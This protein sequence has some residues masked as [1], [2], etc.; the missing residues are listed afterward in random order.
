MAGPNRREFL[1]LAAAL[2]ASLAWGVGCARPA[3]LRWTL[4]ADRFP[5]GV[6]SGDPDE[7]SV[8]LWTRRPPVDGDTAHRVTVEV[9]EDAAFDHVVATAGADVS[10]AS[11]WTAR[12]L[13]AGLAPARVYWYRFVDDRGHGSR[14]GRTVTA[15]EP[16]DPRPV[17]FAFVSCQN[18]CQGAQTAYRRMIFDDEHRASAEQ[19]GFVLHLGDFFYELIW[20]PEDR[21]QGMYARRLRDIVRFSPGEKIAD[22]HVPVSLD[23]YRSLFRAYLLDPDLQDARA[24]WPFV[25]MWDNHEF[26]WKGWQSLV[27]YDTA[28]PAQTRKV[29]AAQAWFEFQPARIVGPAGRRVAEF[30]A[31]A[32]SGAPVADAPIE[33]FDEHGLGQEPNNLAA[34][35]ALRLYRSLRFGAHLDLIL[36]DNR[37]FQMEPVMNRPEAEA[38]QSRPHRYF[39]PEDAIAILDGGR[40]FAGGNPPATIPFGGADHP[41]PRRDHP[42]QTALGVEQKAWF[43]QRLERST[44]T[45]KV[46]GNSFGTLDARTDLH[47]LPAGFGPPWPSTAYASIGGTDWT[48]YRT[49]RAEIFDFV[50]DRRLTGFA[51]VSGDR[52]SFWAGR[53]SRSLPPDAFD[54][55][56][57]EFITGSVSAPGL[58]E[59][60]EFGMPADH[61]LRPLYVHARTPGA[62]LQST[63]NLLLLHGVRSCLEYL[64]TGD[65]TTALAVSNRDLAP[66]LSFLDLGGHGY[67]IVRLD[68]TTMETEFVCIPR[69]LERSDRPDGGP[70]LYRVAHRV[71]LWRPGEPPVLERT[72]L[73]GT[74]SLAT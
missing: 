6:A 7:H 61:P 25:C 41:N 13:A 68:A 5:Q 14:I 59:A 10:A 54:P 65:L 46:W 72:R 40:S 60:A 2:G 62:P 23:D 19:L 57:V 9:A 37:S 63:L 18:A 8:V 66:H 43:L 21:P 3:S 11:D 69:P 67:A 36:T 64:T 52:H 28:R 29:A 26:S 47:N 1:E 71:A 20:Y 31:P 24:R 12:I 73:E 45:W 44:A 53:V 49:E 33:S 15:P 17:Q 27:K 39:T 51:I 35:H 56:G 22:Y 42:P 70:L 4:R 38:F 58:I 30:V 34:I 55:V 32:V 74:P 50:R 16:G 48:G